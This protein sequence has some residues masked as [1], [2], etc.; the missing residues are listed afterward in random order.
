[1]LLDS[2]DRAVD[3]PSVDALEHVADLDLL[4][5]ARLDLTPGSHFGD[6]HAGER[7]VQGQAETNS[8]HRRLRLQLRLRL[9]LRLGLRLH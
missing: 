3:G 9:H 4:Q 7:R 8:D 2:V 5:V 6:Q 1:M